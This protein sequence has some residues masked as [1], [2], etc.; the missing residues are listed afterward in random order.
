MTNKNNSATAICN[1]ISNEKWKCR[2]VQ[3]IALEKLNDEGTIIAK[4]FYDEKMKYVIIDRSMQQSKNWHIK[5]VNRRI[6][7]NEGIVLGSV[8]DVITSLKAFDP[9]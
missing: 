7:N 5:H 2:N 4:S 8:A 1:F 3:L 6:T 9:F